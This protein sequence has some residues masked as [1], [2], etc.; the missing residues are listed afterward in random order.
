MGLALILVL[1]AFEEILEEALGFA[2][3]V[4][5]GAILGL[6]AV[7]AFGATGLAA[8]LGLPLDLDF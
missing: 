3:A 5:A 1:D 8:F 6:A 2:V 7:F 4:F